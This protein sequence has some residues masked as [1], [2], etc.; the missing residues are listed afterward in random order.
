MASET[1]LIRYWMLRCGLVMVALAP[2]VALTVVE[3]VQQP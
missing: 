3:G 2:A 1:A